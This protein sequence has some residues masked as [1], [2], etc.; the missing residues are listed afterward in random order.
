[1]NI[2]KD[3]YRSQLDDERFESCLRVAA[4]QISPRLNNLVTNKRCQFYYWSSFFFNSCEKCI[5]DCNRRS[6]CNANTIFIS[7]CFVGRAS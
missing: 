4:S 5:K 1:M 7:W 3:P 6:K 2:V